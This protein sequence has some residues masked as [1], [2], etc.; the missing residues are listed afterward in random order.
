[1]RPP[2]ASGI[3]AFTDGASH[4]ACTA[5]TLASAVL[6][7]GGHPW[8]NVGELSEAMETGNLCGH[9]LCKLGTVWVLVQLIL[10]LVGL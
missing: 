1:M 5:L 4:P 10:V 2:C 8:K 3:I 9:T 6:G 7:H